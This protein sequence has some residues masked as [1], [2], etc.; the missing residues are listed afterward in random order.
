MESQGCLGGVTVQESVPPPLFVMVSDCGLTVPPATAENAKLIALTCIEGTAIVTLM[1][2]LTGLPAT[3]RPLT[4]SVAV[5]ITVVVEEPLARPVALTTTLEDAVAP[6]ARF[7]PDGGESEI[8]EG[9]SLASV[10]D[11]LSGLPPVLFRLI[12]D[13]VVPGTLIV[14]LEGVVTSTGGPGGV[15]INF[16]TTVCVPAEELKVRVPV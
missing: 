13:D 2:M 9:A 5:I 4:A 3:G 14:I 16:T 1:G 12:G 15:S 10:A 6:A 8:Q 7:A 11:Q